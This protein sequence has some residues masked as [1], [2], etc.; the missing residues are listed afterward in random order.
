MRYGAV[1]EMPF[2]VDKVSV[3]Y[4]LV[5]KLYLAGAIGIFRQVKV[6]YWLIIYDEVI[7]SGYLLVSGAVLRPDI[8]YI[9]AG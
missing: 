5:R 2:P 8:E 3:V 9:S 1:A 4:G 6:G 7:R